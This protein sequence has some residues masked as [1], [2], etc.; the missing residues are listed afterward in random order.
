MPYPGL[1]HPEPPPLQQ[2]T[3]D[4]HH[5]RR[6]P[7]TGLSQSLWGLWVLVQTRCVWASWASLAG[8]SFILNAIL[9]FLQSCWGVSFAPGHGIS[10]QSLS[11]TMQQLHQ[12]L[13]PSLQPLPSSW[14][15]SALGCEESPHSC[16]NA[17]PLVGV[18][19]LLDVGY[20]LTVAQVPLRNSYLCEVKLLSRVWLFPTIAY[21][22]PPSIGFSRQEYWSGLPFLSPGD[23]PNPGLEPRSPSFV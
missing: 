9:T 11:S 10:P 14:G 12:C 13:K 16:S 7:N 19:L 15:F 5:L 1:L 17:Y 21:Q 23:L 6:H 2:A 20:L 18:S 4:P 3:A 8:M 22:A